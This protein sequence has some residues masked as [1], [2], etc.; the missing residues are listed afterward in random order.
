MK[1]RLIST[2]ESNNRVDLSDKIINAFHCAI[3]EALIYVGRTAPN[4]P[5]G[6]VVLDADGVI[7][8]VAAHHQT[9]TLH[10]EAL[11]LKQCRERGVW[12]RI[13]DV[14]V[15]LEPCNHMG[16]TPP[17]SEALL[18]TPAQRIWIG[19][20]DPNPEVCGAGSVRLRQGGKEVIMLDQLPS[21]PAVYLLQKCH[22]LIAP[23]TKAITQQKAWITVKQ[24][25]NVS[26]SMYPSQGQKT[27]TSATS[28]RLAHRLRRGT[29]AIIT[30]VNTIKTDWPSFTV[31]HV[32]DHPNAHRLLVVCSHQNRAL[33]EIVPPQYIDEAKANGFTMIACRAIEQLPELLYQHKVIWGMV[34]AGPYL[35]QEI[36]QQNIWDEWLTIRQKQQ[37]EDQ[38]EIVSKHSE[39]PTRQLLLDSYHCKAKEELCSLV[40]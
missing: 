24:A 8:A 6:C 37:G 11:A 10:A 29:E 20:K 35:L 38:V 3:K 32:K 21:D 23:F 34:E 26:G 17:C 27:F 22:E 13:S 18:K 30:G 33:Q 28:L 14:V 36:R 9:G 7:L 16:R 40:S 2:L 25:V 4:P 1:A 15:T 19:V 31:R 5:V 12:D 39:Y